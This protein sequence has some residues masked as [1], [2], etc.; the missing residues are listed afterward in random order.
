VAVERAV[1]E[2]GVDGEDA[3]LSASDLAAAIRAHLSGRRARL[4]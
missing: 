1:L 4:S 3:L 2:S